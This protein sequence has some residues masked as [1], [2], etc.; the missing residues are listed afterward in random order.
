MCSTVPWVMF[1]YIRRGWIRQ[2]SQGHTPNPELDPPA[3][4]PFLRDTG[5]PTPHPRV[6][7]SHS[8]LSW[9]P[10]AITTRGSPLP[11]PWQGSAAGSHRDVAGRGPLWLCSTQGAPHSP[12]PL[13]SHQ[14]LQRWGSHLQFP[15][16]ETRR[17]GEKIEMRERERR[18]RDGDR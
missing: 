5:P 13:P 7:Q 15:K 6:G 2:F 10:V 12:G 11:R 16:R 17:H 1:L 14:G 9:D 8:R 18:K 3:P 4:I